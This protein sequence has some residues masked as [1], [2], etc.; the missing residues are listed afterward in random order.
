VPST[1]LITNIGFGEM[2]THTKAS[3]ATMAE[4]PTEALEFPLKHPACMVRDK[5]ADLFAFTQICPWAVGQ[6]GFKA[7]ARRSIAPHLPTS[8]RRSIGYFT[9]KSA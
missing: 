6:S 4:L 3:V 7:W 1:N 8:W 9:A 2:A 5:E